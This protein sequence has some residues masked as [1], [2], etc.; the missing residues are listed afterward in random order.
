M[1]DPRQQQVTALRF[2]TIVVASVEKSPE[3]HSYTPEYDGSDDD[4]TNDYT[5]VSS[6]KRRRDTRS[7]KIVAGP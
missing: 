1:V 2:V 4:Y 3:P 5:E 7:C 6:K